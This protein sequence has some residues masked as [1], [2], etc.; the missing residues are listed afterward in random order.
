MERSVIRDRFAILAGA[1]VNLALEKYPDCAALHP[2]YAACLT[3]LP[4]LTR[5]SIL[6]E[7]L[8]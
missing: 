7:R 1:S 8:L 5:Q 4:G 3:S 2:G 6:F